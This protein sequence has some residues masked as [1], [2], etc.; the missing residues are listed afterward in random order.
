MTIVST[1]LETA[2]DCILLFTSVC[3]VYI[4]QYDL[5]ISFSFYK[6]RILIALTISCFFSIILSQNFLGQLTYFKFILIILNFSKYFLLSIYIYKKLSIRSIFFLFI[7]Q[8]SASTITSGLLTFMPEPLVTNHLFNITLHLII[9]LI[10]FF[11]VLTIKNKNDLYSIQM[12]IS[13]IPKYIFALVLISLFLLDGLT[14][15]ANYTTSNIDKK[16]ELIKILAS[17]HTICTTVI[18]LSLLFNVVS[19]KYQSEINV[20]LKKHLKAQLFHYE[21]LEKIN[22]EIRRFKHDY[23]NHMKCLSSMALNKEYDNILNYLDKLSAAFPASSFLFETGN[24]IADA[25][26]TEKQIS[27]P[28]NIS[29][30]FE[31]VI[32]TDID[33]TDL[34]II[35]SN[36]L[37]NAVEACC[38]CSGDQKISVYS[39]FKHGYFILKIKNPTVNTPVNGKIT[40]TKSDKINHG[41][42]LS[43]IK[44][45]VKKYNGRFSTTCENN[46]FTLSIVFSNTD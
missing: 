42:G 33:D 36:A 22:A 19:K 8:Y 46:I 6:N 27:S 39:G 45:T 44:R 41:L 37:D 38:L 30:E 25:I 12:T 34:C 15:T 26:L 13:M 21:Q 18:I 16:I 7:L 3:M 9:R 28:D 2:S 40:T 20:I 24:Y 11:I 43:N 1:I 23:I 4:L 14:Q 5:F 32:P 29:I 10:I 35:L 31:G 17:L